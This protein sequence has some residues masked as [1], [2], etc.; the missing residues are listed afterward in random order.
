MQYPAHRLMRFGGGIR[1]AHLTQHLLLADHHGIQAAGHREQ[2]LDSSLAVPDVGVLGELVH[3]HAGVAGDCLTDHG[4]A[5]VEGLNHGI[6]LDPV[7][8]R[9]HHDLCDQGRLQYVFDDLGLIGLANRQL[10]QHRHRRA[11][12][13]GSEQQDTHR[14]SLR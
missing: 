6:Y 11:T 2:V 3:A 7:A 1:I 14:R 10:L 9:E 13:R 8:G 4:Q 12:V 5:A